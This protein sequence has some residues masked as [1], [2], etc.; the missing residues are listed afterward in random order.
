MPRSSWKGAIEF[1][2]FPINVELYPLVQSRSAKSFKNLCECHDAPISAP[3]TCATTGDTL[4][5]DQIRKGHEVDGAFVVLPQEAVDQIGA[6]SKSATIQI[7]RL[8]KLAS[9]PLH[10]SI[11]H[12]RVVPDRK[13]AGAEQPVQI[14]W[15][16]LRASDRAIITTLTLRAGSRDLLAAIH[17]DEFGLTMTG[18]P[19]AS[20]LQETPEFKPVEN[21]QAAQMFEQFAGVQGIEMLDFSHTAF[22]SEYEARRA[23][24]IE[25][26]VAGN[27]I[28][29]EKVAAPAV[30]VPD[31]MAAMTATLAS[32]PKKAPKA[33]AKAK[34][35]A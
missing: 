6:A 21:E 3:K 16:G 31:L 23:V 2:G 34:A 11:A 20:E 22:E 28:P 9:V 13:V 12:Y 26:A 27:P 8:P 29:V 15:N 5:P 30:T 7:A 24:A 18:L 17:A 35:K 4:A 33:K 25:A 19:F 14:M 10:L 32:A 1:G